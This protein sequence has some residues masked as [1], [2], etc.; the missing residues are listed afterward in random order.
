MSKR[1]LLKAAY[2]AGARD[3]KVNPFLR[4]TADEWVGEHHASTKQALRVQMV[5]EYCNGFYGEPPSWFRE[6]D[7]VAIVRE[8]LRL[9]DSGA[10]HVIDKIRE[11]VNQA[12]RDKATGKLHWPSSVKPGIE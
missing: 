5:E 10:T 12:V 9:L 2:H 11:T 7:Y 8:V 4:E 6:V 1:E 3:E